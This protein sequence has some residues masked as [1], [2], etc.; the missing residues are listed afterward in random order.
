[1]KWSGPF[2]RFKEGWKRARWQE[3]RPRAHGVATG[4]GD[5]WMW[6]S[7][8]RFG[9]EAMGPKSNGGINGRP[10]DTGRR[11]YRVARTGLGRQLLF[12]TTK[13]C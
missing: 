8:R 11:W 13:S 3:G 1:M 6:E 12:Q 4:L 5:M 10:P 2:E 7:Q 9:E